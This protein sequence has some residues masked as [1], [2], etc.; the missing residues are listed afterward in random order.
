MIW[1][2]VSREHYRLLEHNYDQLARLAHEA[3]AQRYADLLEKYHDLAMRQG[4]WKSDI[5]PPVEPMPSNLPEPRSTIPSVVAQAIKDEAE[6]DP[7]LARWLW[8][9]AR[10]LRAEN[11]KPEEIAKELRHWLTTEAD[12]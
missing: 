2:F 8:K 12:G 6:G 4:L 7:K 1:P 10:E 11:M 3:S 9:R 5:G